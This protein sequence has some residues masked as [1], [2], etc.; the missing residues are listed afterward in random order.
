MGMFIRGAS[1]LQTDTTLFR[2]KVDCL[3]FTVL[4]DNLLS[5]TFGLF[6]VSR[7]NSQ[8]LKISLEIWES[9]TMKNILCNVGLLAQTLNVS[10]RHLEL[11]LPSHC[12]QQTCLICLLN[13]TV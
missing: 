7:R 5:R 10:K 8:L 2:L 9:N 6:H 3:F 4:F 1:P 13:V 11:S 12:F